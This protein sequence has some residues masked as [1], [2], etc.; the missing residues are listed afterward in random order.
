MIFSASR[1]NF[2]FLSLMEVHTGEQSNKD[3]QQKLESADKDMKGEAWKQSVQLRLAIHLFIVMG[4]AK[5]GFG[6]QGFV[7][8]YSVFGIGL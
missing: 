3:G 6:L 2:S 4:L 8:T 7:V 5:V 1:T